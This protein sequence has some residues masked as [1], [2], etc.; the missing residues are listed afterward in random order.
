MK[1]SIMCIGGFDIRTYDFNTVVVGSGAAGFNAADALFGFGQKD[2]AIVTENVSAGT[3]RNTGSDKQT[4]YKLTLSGS[5]DDSVRE[6]AKTLFEGQCVDGDIALCEAALSAKCFY[7]LTELGVPF[8]KNRYGEYVGYKTD[9]DPRRRATSA[10]PFTS[11][12]MTESLEQAVRQKGITILDGLQVVKVLTAQN[13]ACGLLCMDTSQPEDES[14][15]FVAFRCRNIIYATGGPAGIYANRVYPDGHYGATGLALEAGVSGRNLTE[16]QYGLASVAPRWNVSGTYMQVLP[17]FISTD[18]QGRDEREF[19]KDFFSTK[20]EMLS[21][22][23]LKGYQWPFDVR[24]L[25]GGSSVIDALVY[26]ETCKGRRVF[27]D[28]RT[29]P[30]E[31]A[32]DFSLLSSEARTYLE[33][34]GACFGTP[35]ERLCH[36]N[37]PAADFYRERGVSLDILPLEIALSA[38]HN[39]GG[40][41]VD[42]WWQTNIE[43]LFAA[44]EA[45]ASHG[46]YRPGGSALNA[47]QVGSLRAAE[48]IVAKRLGKPRKD[49][50][51]LCKAGITECVE[52][53]RALLARQEDNIDEL[54]QRVTE[55]MSMF[56]AAVRN[57]NGMLDSLE[58][59]RML[60]KDFGTTASAGTPASLPGA[61]RLRDAAISQ[62]VYLSAMLDYIRQGGKSRGSALYTDIH[63][64]KPYEALPDTFR[65]AL[66]DGSR[67]NL[68]QEVDLKDGECIFHWRRVRP[69]P[70]DDDFFENTWRT[71]RANGNI[72]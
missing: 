63:S 49:L 62:F 55:R 72:D 67:G 65:F 58:H 23:F 16:W 26:L 24:K 69:L 50:F 29:N 56:G 37:Q 7:K 54:T 9:H 11:R 68:I 5:D 10:G 61:Y 1:E 39:N 4:Y 70:D 8:P 43:G 19:L 52:L 36:M 57:E 18:S 33:N 60:L 64:E 32:I 34:A 22:V 31:Q 2:I 12:M 27:L 48:F 25:H 38:Q 17:R 40:L 66:D 46:V 42:R 6:M 71:Y 28:F 3:S 14:R 59:I 41:A 20:S 44:G 51:R 15:R 53:S 21:K 30:F 47:G 13:H 35:Y 45:S